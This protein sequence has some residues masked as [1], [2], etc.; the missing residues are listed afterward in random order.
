MVQ[1]QTAGFGQLPQKKMKKEN[2]KN[3]HQKT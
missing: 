3:H 1:F 2:P